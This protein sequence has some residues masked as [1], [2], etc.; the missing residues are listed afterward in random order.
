MGQLT[1]ADQGQ[2]AEDM[3]N[4][5]RTNF[6]QAQQG[7]TNAQDY[8]QKSNQASTGVADANASKVAG[9]AGGGAASAA[10]GAGMN[11]AQAAAMGSN[12]AA[13]AYGNAWGNMYGAAQN[14]YNNQQ[15]RN[16]EAGLGY[17]G[18]ATTAEANATNAQQG[19]LGNMEKLGGQWLKSDEKTKKDIKHPMDILDAVVS[20]VKPYAYKYKGSNTERIGPMAQDLEKSP[21]AYTV[22]TG[23]DGLKRVDTE[24]LTMANTSLITKL[25]EEL[26]KVKK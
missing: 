7:G 26:K 21:L 10:M 6:E 16:T 18:N 2:N 11:P 1:G 12:A 5:A 8:L 9:N 13:G 17:A 3:R 19:F 4:R 24:A 15:Q 22:Q 23:P 25:A 20:T 14:A